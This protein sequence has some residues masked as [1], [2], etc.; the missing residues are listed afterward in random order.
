MS[1][2]EK[3]LGLIIGLKTIFGDVVYLLTGRIRNDPTMVP[4]LVFISQCC[5]QRQPA[6]LGKLQGTNILPCTSEPADP[7][8]QLGTFCHLGALSC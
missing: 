4:V 1:T 6:T 3:F 2:S 7:H 5:P 8:G